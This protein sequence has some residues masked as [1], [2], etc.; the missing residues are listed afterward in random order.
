MAS[1]HVR[2]FENQSGNWMQIGNDIDGESAFNSF[3]ISISL[4]SNGT[5]LAVGA[6]R[7]DG[8][9]IDSGH[10]RVFQNRQEFSQ[11]LGH[12]ILV[13]MLGLTFLEHRTVFGCKI[14]RFV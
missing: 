8:N 3:G 6:S 7:N 14:T 4:N 9:G 2:V 11:R 1:G 5:I 12:G 10:V 13:F